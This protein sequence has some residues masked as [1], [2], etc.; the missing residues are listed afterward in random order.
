MIHQLITFHVIHNSIE[1]T[2]YYYIAYVS[3]AYINE[4]VIAS[5]LCYFVFSANNH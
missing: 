3:K 1:I 2:S 5:S 4:K